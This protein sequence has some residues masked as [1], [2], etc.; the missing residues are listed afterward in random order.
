[1]LLVMDKDLGFETR[2]LHLAHE[3]LDLSLFMVL[4]HLLLLLDMLLVLL[5]LLMLD[6]LLDLELIN[7][8]PLLLA[9]DL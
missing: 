8:L 4:K 1:M 5:V 2:T 3:G 9:L 7:Q 6:W